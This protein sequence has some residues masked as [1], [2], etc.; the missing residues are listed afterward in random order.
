VKIFAD[1]IGVKNPIE[2][3]I[4]L[5]KIGVD[6]VGLHIGIDQQLRSDFD[7]I[8]FPTLKKLKESVSIP[9]AVAGGLK[10]ETIPEAIDAGADVLIVG[11]AITRSADP[12]EAT[13][14][15]KEIIGSHI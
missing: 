12:L 4:Q 11:G 1:L 8:P 15:L 2:R 13:K 10:A 3:A 7:K 14:R 6:I 5:E 9:I